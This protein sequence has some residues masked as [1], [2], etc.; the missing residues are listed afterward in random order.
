MTRTR[1]GA[2]A[3]AEFAGRTDPTMFSR[4]GRRGLV[5]MACATVAA[6]GMA[7]AAARAQ[8]SGLRRDELAIE[9]ATGTHRFT[10]ELPRTP[11]QMARGLMHR[12][13]LAADAGMLFLY[14]ADRAITMWMKNTLIPLDMLFIAADGRITRIARDTQP[15]SLATISSLGAVTGV[16]EIGGGESERLGIEVGDR[17]LHPEFSAASRSENAR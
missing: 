3:A 8:D 6:I 12:R 7:A 17:V 13:Q 10:V 16:L 11:D 2:V 4:V 15:L 1:A 9:S 5:G 14:P